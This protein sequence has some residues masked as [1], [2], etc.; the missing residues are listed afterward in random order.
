MRTVK[1]IINGINKASSALAL[2]GGIFAALL[3][4][5]M[6]FEVISRYIFQHPTV[7]SQEINQ[8]LFCAMI[9]L[10]GCYTLRTNGHVSVDIVYNKMNPRVQGIFDLIGSIII[11][12]ILIITFDRTLESAM[13]AIKWQ[14]T[15]GTVFNSHTYYA[16]FSIPVGTGFFLLQCAA[17]LLMNIL[18]II[19]GT[20]QEETHNEVDIHWEEGGSVE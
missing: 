5:L 4:F 19:T 17:R 13:D 15:T 3:M 7:W 18:Q 2:I 8:Y 9:A 16:K 12:A 20:K 1:K 10:G 11:V 6:T 14:E